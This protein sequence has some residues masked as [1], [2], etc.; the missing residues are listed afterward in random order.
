MYLLV[1]HSGRQVFGD[2]PFRRGEGAPDV[3]IQVG[4]NAVPVELIQEVVLPVQH[5]RVQGP[6]AIRD[7]APDAARRG[8]G[9]VMVHAHAVDSQLGQV[10][11]NRFGVRVGGEIGAEAEVHAPDPQA[12]GTGKEMPVLDVGKAVRSCRHVREP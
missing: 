4:V 11:G 2:E 9:V 8:V 1:L 5:V 10:G 3:E 12:I 6:P 7:R